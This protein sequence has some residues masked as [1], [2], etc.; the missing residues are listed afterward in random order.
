M[1]LYV[2]CGSK[3]FHESL[4]RLFTLLSI[5]MPSGFLLKNCL[6]TFKCLISL[7]L[8]GCVDWKKEPDISFLVARQSSAEWSS[9]SY[10]VGRSQNPIY[11]GPCL[12]PV[13]PDAFTW[14]PWHSHILGWQA[15]FP[16]PVCGWA[17]LALL[18]FWMN[19]RVILLFLLLGSDSP[20]P[21]QSTWIHLGQVTW[22]RASFHQLQI[23]ST[24]LSLPLCSFCSF[25]F[26]RF[27]LK[28]I[29][30]N[31]IDFFSFS[32]WFYFVFSIFFF[33]YRKCWDLVYNLVSVKLTEF[34]YFFKWSWHT[35]T[36]HMF[37]FRFIK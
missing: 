13:G 35:S 22:I 27:L 23:M 15:G 17:S 16:L 29:F 28:F 3:A 24:Y 21:A 4:E 2:P 8:T 6:F 10:W 19:I 34:N 20:G 33:L 11:V 37:L 25:M 31:C 1:G 18:L 26:C 12:D 9:L 36:N 5:D 32:I 30:E 7:E 14:P